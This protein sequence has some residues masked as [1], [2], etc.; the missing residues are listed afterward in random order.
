MKICC[1][2]S[3]LTKLS[4]VP[5]QFQSLSANCR[6]YCLFLLSIPSLV[7]IFSTGYNRIPR[8]MDSM[9]SKPNLRISVHG[10][11]NRTAKL[12]PLRCSNCTKQIDLARMG[13]PR[14]GELRANEEETLSGI[15]VRR[16]FVRP[17]TR[18]RVGLIGQASIA[19]AVH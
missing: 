12:S 10:K 2:G 15:R 8:E 6:I 7:S 5:L 9:D 3:A 1:E 11:R 13:S 4:Y 14:A 19:L 17:R 18:T 16:R